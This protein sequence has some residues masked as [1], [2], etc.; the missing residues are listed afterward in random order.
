MSPADTIIA[1]ASGPGHS[2][3][4][5]LRLSGPAVP[6][7]AEAF[8]PDWTRDASHASG[9]RSSGSAATATDFR[10]S[11]GRS[12]RVLAQ[13][14]PA[15]GSYTGQDSLEL[16]IP[17]G[18]ALVERV[19]GALLARAE[20]LSIRDAS[21]G[22]FSARAYLAGRLTLAQAE[23]VAAIIAAGTE[24]E[25]AAA[26]AL[27]RPG[28]GAGA[29]PG[30]PY[31]RWVDELTTLLALV[32]SGVDFSDQED[33]IPI[34]SATLRSRLEA[35]AAAMASTLGGD[36]GSES[37]S[38]LPAVVLAGAPNAGKSTL[39]NALL[40]RTRAIES[41]IAGTTRDVLRE[42]LS[43]GSGRAADAATL[44]GEFRVELADLAGLDASAPVTSA[45][46]DLAAAEHAKAAIAAADVV[47]WCDPK[48]EFAAAPWR[49]ESSRA[50]VIRVITKS[51]LR[52]LS[53]R[54][55]PPASFGVN[56]G[57][58]EDRADRAGS[59]A[60]TLAPPLRVCAIDR[61][62]LDALREAILA[63]AWGDDA[64]GSARGAAGRTLL[65]R[66]RRAMVRALCAAREAAHLIDPAAR[67]LARPELVAH[68]LRV[69]LDHAGELVGRIEPDAVL[70]RVFA[71]FCIG[72]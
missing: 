31:Q 47:L 2:A 37:P 43:L 12:L 49:S 72:K 52:A 17:G 3:R 22:E 55:T 5:L 27:L 15:G 24:A 46:S 60:D 23:G 36:R 11:D 40:G 70:G 45:A 61:R 30:V 50:R 57:S 4:A 13:Q 42:S 18:P 48:G 64:A 38:W 26:R 28:G 63:A 67:A 68:E 59:A 44:A 1:L 7:V 21:P 8:L 41:P 34:A 51:D 39:F 69:A 16:L 53:T 35:L 65:P 14:F 25:L 54:A 6:A 10:F 20:N 66:H 71:T 32:E 58:L 62:G 29:D 33:V 56:R 19:I 9:D